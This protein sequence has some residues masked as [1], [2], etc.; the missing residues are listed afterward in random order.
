MKNHVGWC[1]TG[2]KLCKKRDKNILCRVGIEFDDNSLSSIVL[3][4]SPP[5]RCQRLHKRFDVLTIKTM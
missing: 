5:K 1:V 2:E 4:I 3:I